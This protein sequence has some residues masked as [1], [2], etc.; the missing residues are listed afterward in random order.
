ML[1][2]VSQQTLLMMP[3]AQNGTLDQLMSL[4]QLEEG[5]LN[6]ALQQL[7]R[8]SLVQVGGDVRERRYMIH[9]LTETFLL[10]EAIKWKNS[11]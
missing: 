9:R 1:D 6:P 10:N 11:A 8:L 2:S 3:L 4:T 5:E 7:A